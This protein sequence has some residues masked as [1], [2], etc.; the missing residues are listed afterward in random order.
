MVWMIEEAN[1][2][3]ISRAREHI[4]TYIDLVP[5]CWEVIDRK[6]AI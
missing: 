2:D 1:G 6:V 3:Q 5:C 4:Y